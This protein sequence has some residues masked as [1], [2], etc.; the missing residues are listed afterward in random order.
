MIKNMIQQEKPQIFFMQ[1]TKCNSTTLDQTLIKAWPGSK[2]VA[3][4]A[5]GASGGLATAWD[6]RAITLN[7]I[8][9][10]N[11]CIQAMFRIIRTN[12][13]GHLTN[14][15]F[16]QKA[17]NKIGIL[18]TVTLINSTRIHLLWIKGRDF[19]MIIKLEEKK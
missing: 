14:F 8:H 16:P 10:N 17:L 7:N 2:A 9:A 1:E 3:V 4:D 19:N 6:E 15:Y 18:N 13:H 12:V 5:L 11:H